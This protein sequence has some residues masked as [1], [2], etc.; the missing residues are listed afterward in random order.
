MSNPTGASKSRKRRWY[1]NL[2]DAYRLAADAEPWLGWALLGTVLAVIGAGVGIGYAVGH[3]VY[4]GFLG[5]MLGLTL[6]MSLL[7]WRVRKVT[8]AQIEGQ[9]GASI[10]VLDQ[11]KRGWNIEREP[12]AVN[13][14]T[15]DLVFRMV[16]RP[17]IVLISEGP[18]ARTKKLLKDEERKVTRVAPNVPVHFIQVGNEDDQV[19][20]AKLQSAV[21]KLPKKLTAEEVAQVANRLRSLGGVRPPIPKGIDPYR[22]RPNRKAMK[23]R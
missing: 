7:A 8:Y 20:L 13:P 4:A 10:A 2:F 19:P 9:P 14:R 22:A 16:G 1:H 6:A 11:I 18:A 15:Q 3:P 5:G 17:G 12:V 23:G 21:R